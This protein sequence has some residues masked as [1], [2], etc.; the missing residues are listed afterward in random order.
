[1]CFLDS[2]HTVLKKPSILVLDCVVSGLSLLPSMYLSSILKDIFKQIN[3]VFHYN[4]YKVYLN[5]EQGF[6]L[7]LQFLGNF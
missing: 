3:R 1:M 2:L 5:S 6:D 4:L 7:V